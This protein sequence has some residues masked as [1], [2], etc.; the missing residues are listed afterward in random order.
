MP[1]HPQAQAVCDLTNATR[2]TV[3]PEE[4]VQTTRERWGLYLAMTGGEPQ[5]VHAVEDRDANG[6]PVRVYHPSGATN[7]PIFVV[8]HGGGWVI[9]NVDQYDGIARW[10]ANASG[11][12]V[13]SVDYRLAPEHPYPA[14]LDDSWTAVRWAADHATEIGGDPARIA[15]GGDSA[16]G[17]LA[18]VCA[19]LARD[20]GGPELALQVLIYPV[21]DC[22]FGTGSYAA[23]GEGYVLGT[24]EMQWFFDNYTTGHVD[25]T[26]WH[27]SPLRVADAGG[28]APALVLTAEYDPL[29]D[30]GQAY[31]DR[32]RAAGVDVEYRCYEGMI[33]SFFGLP[34]FDT[35]RDAMDFVATGLQRAFGTLDP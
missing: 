2:V 18:A 13:V 26:D 6:V 12:L 9:G 35:A 17:N 7:L 4:R 24:D 5:P 10:L 8:F 3:A 27:V 22:N 21:V 14:P 33:H 29:R 34:A 25:P 15:V 23:N 31:A 32:L 19:L 30:E 16:G 20:A 28:V 1:L 11:A